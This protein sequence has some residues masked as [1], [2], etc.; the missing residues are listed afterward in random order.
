[1]QNIAF[2]REKAKSHNCYRRLCDVIPGGVN[3]PIRSFKGLGTEPVVAHSGQGD[4]LYDVD[5]NCYIDYCLSWGPLPHGH[6]H[7][8]IVAAVQERVALGTTFGITTEIEMKLAEKII[9]HVPSVE[10]IRFVSSGTEATMS[11]ARVARGYTGKKI[12]VKFAGC[13]HGH[14]DFFLV[15]A[16]SGVLGLNPSSTSAGIPEEI[17]KH[18]V[19]LEF[20]DVEGCRSFLLDPKNRNDIAAVIIEPIAGNMGCVPASKEFLTM[21]RETTKEIG[22]LL[23]FDEVIVGFRVGLGG[24]QEYYGITPDMTCFGKIIGGGFPAAAFGGKK[25]IM[26]VLAPLGNVYQAGTLSG[27]PVAMTAGLKTLEMLEEEGVFSE[28]ERKARVITG[29]VKELI[30]AKGLNACVQE[31]GSM[32]TIFFGKKKVES[33]RDVRELD[34]AEFARFFRYML[35]NGVYIPPAQQETWFVSTVHREENLLRTRDLILEYLQNC[36]L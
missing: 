25:E 10:K 32:F 24:A 16:G 1:M 9:Q 13:Y 5:G 17:V 12:L 7:P 36:I 21:L 3:S 14:A 20:N 35:E 33:V 31:V 23:I 19:C 6:A 2:T 8:E 15:Q 29:P 18:T 30:E 26:N 28:L 27:N 11:A 34:F 4:L 22:S